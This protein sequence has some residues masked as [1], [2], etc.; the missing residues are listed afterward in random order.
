MV[1]KALKRGHDSKGRRYWTME[2]PYGSWAWEFQLARDLEEMI[3]RFRILWQV[4]CP[5]HD[6]PLPL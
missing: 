4:V 6:S 1:L 5:G 2:H 3:L